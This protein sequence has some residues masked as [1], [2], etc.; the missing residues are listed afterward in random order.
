MF[1]IQNMNIID[2]TQVNIEENICYICLEST[3]NK[4]DCKCQSYVCKKCL[5]KEKSYRTECSICKDVFEKNINTIEKNQYS[6]IIKIIECGML[7][8]YVFLIVCIQLLFIVFGN[9]FLRKKL[10]NLSWLSYIYGILIWLSLILLFFILQGIYAIFY[11]IYK[12]CR[13]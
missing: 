2:S 11:L 9:L 7:I 1:I 8:F 4:S 3:G 12:N 6:C 10:L 13:R 5:K